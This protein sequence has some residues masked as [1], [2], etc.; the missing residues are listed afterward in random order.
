MK[1]KTK[2]RPL[3]PVAKVEIFFRGKWTHVYDVSEWASEREW[4]MTFS[5]PVKK[6]RVVYCR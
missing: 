4:S 5:E 1:A 6:M 3:V 2:M